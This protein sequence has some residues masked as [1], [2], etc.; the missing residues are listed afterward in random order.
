MA[1]YYST[2]SAGANYYSSRRSAASNR[3]APNRNSTRHTAGINLGPISQSVFMIAMVAVL[4]ILFLSQST[5][6]TTYDHR[7]N[8]INVELADLQAERDSLAVENAKINAAA[9]SESENRVA[10]NMVSATSS[11]YV[12]E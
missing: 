6:V 4:G 11:A 7:I 5:S 10:S 9:A 1:T 12:S 8:D 3:F 2:R